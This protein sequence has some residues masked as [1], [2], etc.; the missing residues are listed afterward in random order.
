MN[1]DLGCDA[2]PRDEL[3]RPGWAERALVE[4]ELSDFAAKDAL[5]EAL[6]WPR[7]EREPRAGTRRVVW[8]GHPERLDGAPFWTLYRPWPASGDGWEE[9]PYLIAQSRLVRARLCRVLRQGTGEGHGKPYAWVELEVL[10]VERIDERDPG[11]CASVLPAWLGMGDRAGPWSVNLF[12]HPTW[13]VWQASDTSYF[14]VELLL[15]R[16]D[17]ALVARYGRISA[18]C[19]EL[20]WA[21]AAK[22]EAG[23]AEDVL[24]PVCRTLFRHRWIDEGWVTERVR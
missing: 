20:V 6:A 15:A 14:D 16:T 24:R 13:V 4:T 21:G 7:S 17:G 23:A 18:P 19:T 3:A 9:H 1:L 5:P 22:L 12:L 8:I 2:C 11:A 10:E